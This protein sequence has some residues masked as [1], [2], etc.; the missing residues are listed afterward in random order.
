MFDIKKEV[1]KLE[2]ELI[3]LR[4]RIHEHPELGY[5]EFETSALV[6][7]RL[8]EYG[9]TDIRSVTGT[10]VTAVLEG[11]GEGKTLLFRADMDALPVT[12]ETGLPFASKNPGVMHA[13]GHDSHTAIQLMTA[14]LLSMHRD[15]FKGRIKFLFQPNEEEAGALNM[16]NEGVLEDPHVDAALALHL[17]SPV[18][19]GRIAISEG[20]VLGTTEEFELEII[21]KQGHTSTPHTGRD[22]L[23]GACSV[24]QAVQS[25]GTREFDPLLPIAIMFGYINGGT[26][27]NVITGN[28]KLG[29][30]IRF[31]FP[32]EEHNKPKV[33]AAFERVI[34]GQCEALGLTYKLKYIPSNPSLNNDP[35][36]VAIVKK[37]AF[38]TYGTQDNVDSFRSLAGEDF[39]EFT[40]RV[41]SAMTFVGVADSGK[42]SD[43]PHH[44]S[45]FDIDESVMKYA[46]E[47]QVR[48]ALNYLNQ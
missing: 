29:G 44:H 34:R 5:Q 38:E 14:K 2:P 20:P 17:W 41:P 23:L 33:L 4:R 9:L 8:E 30:T 39:A 21:G 25:L 37:S 1:A 6:K 48:N 18:K 26:A 43:F 7:Q 11:T 16:I 36:M 15:S 31:L 10:G 47:L 12:E 13:C 40:Y 28:V 42:K 45:H 3:D 22:A 27:R 19:S 46:V 24:V 35:A 32:D